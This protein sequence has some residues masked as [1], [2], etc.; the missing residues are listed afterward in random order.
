MFFLERARGRWKN[1]DILLVGWVVGRKTSFTFAGFRWC[2]NRW[3]LDAFTSSVVHVLYTGELRTKMTDEY[4]R[5]TIFVILFAFVK[6]SPTTK[7]FA[8]SPA[9]RLKLRPGLG[10]PWCWLWWREISLHG[11]PRVMLGKSGSESGTGGLWVKL[12]AGLG[13][14]WCK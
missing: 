5:R 3:C 13:V 11:S 8:S 2:G 10:E 7:S 6:F 4:R 12:R 1:V 14:P 9:I